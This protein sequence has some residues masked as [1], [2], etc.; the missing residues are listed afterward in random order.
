MKNDEA[1]HGSEAIALGASELPLPVGALMRLA[2]R[3]MTGTA[4]YI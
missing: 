4:H 1:R 3:L 2:A